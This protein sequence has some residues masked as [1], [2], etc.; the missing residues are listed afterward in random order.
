[1]DGMG[2]SCVRGGE[3]LRL[4]RGDLRKLSDCG[5]GLRW[6]G[7]AVYLLGVSFYLHKRDD[8]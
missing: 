3:R 5:A 2:D 6:A 7:P 8:L 4:F 1:M